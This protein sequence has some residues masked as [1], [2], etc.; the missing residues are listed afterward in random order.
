MLVPL[1]NF[2]IVALVSAAC[3]YAADLPHT[4]ARYQDK[5]KAILEEKSYPLFWMLDHNGIAKND[6]GLKKLDS[7]R[8]AAIETAMACKSAACTTEAFK[9][10]DAEITSAGEV[11]TSLYEKN[12]IFRAEANK[13]LRSGVYAFGE[14]SAEALKKALAADAAGVNTTI[15]IY[16]EAAPPPYPKIDAMDFDPAGKDFRGLVRAA[17]LVIHDD[18][19]PSDL[20]FTPN[21][22]FALSLLRMNDREDAARFEPMEKGIN[23]AAV[24]RT[25]T[26]AWSKYP[27]SAIVIPG[28]GPEI[29]GQHISPLGQLHVAL[30]VERYREG[31]APFIIVSGG[32]AHPAHTHFVEAEE[33][34]RELMDRYGV[35]ANAIIAEPHARHTTTNLRNV[36]REVIHYGLP[37]N[38]PLLIVCNEYQASM[39]ANHK[40]VDR[41][42]RELG[43]LPWLTLKRLGPTELEFT[44]NKESLRV[45]STSPLEP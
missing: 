39:I 15:A 20:F 37:M 28:I 5:Y 38:R 7:H 3:F 4:S 40:F 13:L 6:A 8:D 14:P 44:P 43:Y 41:N 23:A 32:S 21:V 11:L 17:T 1:R 45:S 30:A 12:A 33:M 10:S 19:K 26:I 2:T 24:A 9:I 29:V 36:V 34:R 31:N 18:A 35:P 42:N 27:Y 25:R 16:G 22:S